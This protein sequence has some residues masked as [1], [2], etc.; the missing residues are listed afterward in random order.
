MS[1]EERY[2]Y[3]ETSIMRRVGASL[4]AAQKKVE[5]LGF[6]K[7]GSPVVLPRNA[8]L[9][10]VFSGYLNDMSSFWH[11]FVH[12]AVWVKQGERESG[13]DEGLQTRLIQSDVLSY[14]Q[15]VKDHKLR[16]DFL[17]AMVMK[18]DVWDAKPCLKNRKDVSE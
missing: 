4:A 16:F 8:G 11:C 18:T 9:L 17:K 14:E 12:V 3:T 7:L 13:A 2:C 5:Y 15:N 6:C 10:A 1:G